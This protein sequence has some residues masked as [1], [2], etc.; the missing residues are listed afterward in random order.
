MLFHDSPK[1]NRF[2]GAIFSGAP[3]GQATD[4]NGILCSTA[5][6]LWQKFMKTGSTHGLPHSGQPWK[7]TTH[8]ANHVIQESKKHHWALLWELG[9][10]AGT[11]VSASMVCWVLRDEGHH[12]RKAWKVV[13]LTKNHWKAQKA[14]AIWYKTMTAEDWC[15]VIWSNEC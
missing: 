8:D 13:M 7:L 15:H 2:I 9:Y 4:Q 1:K 6:Q 14:W 3:K 10:S 11:E 5:Q 12:Q